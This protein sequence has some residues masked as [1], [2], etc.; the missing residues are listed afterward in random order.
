LTFASLS[1]SCSRLEPGSSSSEVGSDRPRAISGPRSRTPRR[2]SPAAART[3]T[4][5]TFHIPDKCYSKQGNAAQSRVFCG[6][7]PSALRSRL[8]SCKRKEERPR[9]ASPLD[10]RVPTP[11][12]PPAAVREGCAL[13]SVDGRLVLA[14]SRTR[15]PREWGLV[16]RECPPAAGIRRVD[17]IRRK[18]RTYRSKLSPIAETGPCQPQPDPTPPSLSSRA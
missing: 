13:G 17:H 14:T 18:G 8:A 10:R 9:S 4:H 6:R 15:S 2:C 1:S 16:A 3:P 5:E 12:Y 11:W 7:E